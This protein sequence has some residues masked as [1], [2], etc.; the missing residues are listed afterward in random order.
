MGNWGNTNGALLLHDPLD[1][2]GES[3]EKAVDRGKKGVE[4]GAD[5]DH[6]SGEGEKELSVLL[7]FLDRFGKRRDKL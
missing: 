2:A 6:Q 4:A 1:L 3:G 7:L 5:L